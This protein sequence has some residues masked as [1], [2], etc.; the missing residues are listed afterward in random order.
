MKDDELKSQNVSFDAYSFEEFKDRFQS[1]GHSNGLLSLQSYTHNMSHEIK[2]REEIEQANTEDFLKFLSKSPSHDVLE[3]VLDDKKLLFKNKSGASGILINHLER[4]FSRKSKTLLFKVLNDKDYQDSQAF[5]ELKFIDVVNNHSYLDKDDYQRVFDVKSFEL[6][7]EIIDCIKKDKTYLFNSEILKISKEQNIDVFDD[8][9]NDPKKIVKLI[10]HNL[11]LIDDLFGGEKD[12]ERV[13]TLIK[14]YVENEHSTLILSLKEFA[15]DRNLRLFDN[16]SIKNSI[17]QDMVKR[18]NTLF[19]KAKKL[20]EMDL[21]L[22]YKSSMSIIKKLFLDDDLPFDDYEADYLMEDVVEANMNVKT[23]DFVLNSERF[24]S[25]ARK[26][27]FSKI[28]ESRELASEKDKINFDIY[29]EKFCNMESKKA[30]INQK[31]KRD[32]KSKNKI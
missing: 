22:D 26:D 32:S 14:P 2:E 23:K 1:H 20:D 27:F 11:N 30:D 8:F 5:K 15:E 12:T 29:Y 16:D 6:K 10:N 13:L 17:I 3:Q 28:N 25:E 24:N 9:K 7:Q 19:V 4:S 18:P 31:V 21:N